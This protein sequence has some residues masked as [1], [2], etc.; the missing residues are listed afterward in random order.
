[1]TVKDLL[2]IMVKSNASDLYLTVDSP[3]MFRV[4]GVTRPYG[5]TKISSHQSEEIAMTIMSERQKAAFAE[6]M[7]MNLGIYYPEILRRVFLAL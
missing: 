2:L 7:E 4:E 3:P 6:N 5:E 1:M